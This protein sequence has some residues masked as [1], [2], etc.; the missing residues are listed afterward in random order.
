MERML[1]QTQKWRVDSYEGE[2]TI[3]QVCKILRTGD[4]KRQPC[5]MVVTA[6][7]FS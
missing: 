2:L 5:R 3:A 4:V 6:M 7:T 1:S